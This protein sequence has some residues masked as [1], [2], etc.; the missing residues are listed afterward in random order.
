[1]DGNHRDPTRTQHQHP[2]TQGK[3]CVGQGFGA[4]T[5]NQKQRQNLLLTVMELGEFRG[6][7]TR[8]SLKPTPTA[9]MFPLQRDSGFETSLTSAL[10]PPALTGRPNSASH[11]ISTCA[12]CV[13]YLGLSWREPAPLPHSEN[14]T[15]VDAL[16]E[17]KTTTTTS[18]G[19]VCL[20]Q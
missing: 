19:D 9:C 3:C 2:Q 8:G 16:H 13:S 18:T 15:A 6:A 4:N 12:A 5:Q 14:R 1:M 20:H 11:E 10:L 7:A 17:V